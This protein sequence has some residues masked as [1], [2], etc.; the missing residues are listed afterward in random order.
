MK[1]RAEHGLTP[2]MRTEAR[3]TLA[4]HAR[5][6]RFAALFLTRRV[7]DD[8]ALVYRFCRSVDDYADEAASAEA[9]KAALQMVRDELE[10]QCPMTPSVAGYVD[11]QRRLGI[12][13][14]AAHHLLDGATSDLEAVRI[15]TTQDLCDYAYQV[16]GVVGVM[17]CS[18]LRVPSDAALP[19]AVDLG[20]AMQITNI[21]RDVLEDAERGRVY[22]PRE[23]LERHGI[24]QDDLLGP[25]RATLNLKPVID[26]LL[27]LAERFYRRGEYGL[28]YIPLRSRFS[29]LV[30][31]RVYRS[32]G[33][34]LRKQH[35]SNPLFG[36][37]VTSLGS[38]LV[39]GLIAAM[40]VLAPRWLGLPG[41]AAPMVVVE[42]AP[43]APVEVQM[44]LAS[45]LDSACSEVPSC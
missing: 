31:L 22:L 2:A 9:A 27:D 20:I 10:G 29:I 28:R 40:Q 11:V 32:I 12:P 19:Y 15:Q 21:C 25:D 14:D 8:A 16:A 30:A 26:E 43:E 33:R 34:K 4:T 5:S 18:V 3:S 23:V 6:F 24:A 42:S 35:G 37:T 39:Q 13:G 36:R 38:K 41:E 1:S 44:A 45:P 17:M 7:A